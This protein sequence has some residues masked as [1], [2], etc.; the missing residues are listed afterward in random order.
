MEKAVEK[1][2]VYLKVKEWRAE[3]TL[4]KIKQVYGR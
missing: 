3:D 4:N 2:Q 1:L